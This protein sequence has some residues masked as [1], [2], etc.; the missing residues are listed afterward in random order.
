MIDLA[1]IT[2]RAGSQGLPGKNIAELGGVPLIAWTV[3]AAL[4]SGVFGRVVVS[5]DDAEIAA[6]ARAAGAEVPFLRPVELATAEARSVEV[7]RHALETLA[8]SGQFALLQPTS[9]FRNAH[10]LREAAARLEAVG[11]TSLISVVGAKPLSWLF[12]LDESGRLCCANTGEVPVSRRQDAIPL[13]APNGAIYLC[14]TERFLAS[15][16]LRFDDTLGYEMSRIDSVDIDDPEDLALA[17]A[18]VSQG[19]REID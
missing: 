13:Y 10:H 14:E 6:A 8:V 3:R 19:L 5:T 9:P 15:T 1:L 4:A 2:A 11:G 17:R 12:R 18:I 7:V 16:E